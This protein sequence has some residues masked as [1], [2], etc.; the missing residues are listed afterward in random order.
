MII[1][2]ELEKIMLEDIKRREDTQKTAEGPSGLF[3]ILI[4]KYYCIF[5]NFK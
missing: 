2:E 3:K 5:E 4:S 1:D